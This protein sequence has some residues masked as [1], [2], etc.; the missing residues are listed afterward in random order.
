LRLEIL[1][2]AEKSLISIESNREKL[3]KTSR[4]ICLRGSFHKEK[5]IKGS[6]S[7][8]N[9]LKEKLIGNLLENQLRNK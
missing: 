2:S 9:S 1:I 8:G 5:I 7:R 3:Q 4:E 6:R